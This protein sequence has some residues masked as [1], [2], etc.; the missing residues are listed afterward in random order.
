M[1]YGG[2]ASFPD[3]G[4]VV[5]SPLKSRFCNFTQ[6]TQEFGER[7]PVFWFLEREG[8]GSVSSLCLSVTANSK[9]N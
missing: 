5:E 7:W 6:L 1:L 2:R 4:S 3:S 8:K 9:A